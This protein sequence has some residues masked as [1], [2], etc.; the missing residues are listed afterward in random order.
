MKKTLLAIAVAAFAA[1]SV[2]AAEIYKG[3]DATVGFYGQLRQ[4][5]T[6]S[7]VDGGDDVRIDK[8]SSRWGVNVAYKIEEGL[9]FVGKAEVGVEGSSLRQHYVGVDSEKF[10]TLTVGQHLPFYDDVYGAV[11]NWQFDETPYQNG[12]ADNF[13]QPSSIAYSVAKENFWLKASHNLSENDG[14]P[15]M[16]E[17]YVGTAFGAL[18]LHV[19]GAFMTDKTSSTSLQ[20]DEAA[21]G[22]APVYV[23]TN[24]NKESTYGE[25][26][27]EYALANGVVGFTYAY[28]KLEDKN[29]SAKDSESNSFHVGGKFKVADKTSVYAQY[30]YFDFDEDIDATTNVMVGAEYKFSSWALMYAEYNFKAEDGEDDA[31]NVALGA[32]VY[33]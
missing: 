26:T 12:F 7:D 25:A 4:L 19:G 6:L 3:D 13:W 32:R 21:A 23:T 17:A 15:Q 14:D 11:Y 10:G 27:V 20:D 18:S 5:V 31:N 2:N 9:S 8:S 28:N 29:N 30:Q 24:N 33:W 22:A 1:S 16:T